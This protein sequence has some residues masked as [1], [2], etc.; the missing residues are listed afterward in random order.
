M[1]YFVTNGGLALE[2]ECVTGEVE[3]LTAIDT[4]VPPPPLPKTS[5]KSLVFFDLETTGLPSVA[6]RANITEL[7]MVAVDRQTF[8]KCNKFPFRVSNKLVHCIKPS[9][10][11]HPMAAKK[12]GLDNSM[13]V[14]QPLFRDIVPALK[15]FLASL[16]QPVCLLAHNGDRFDFPILQEELRYAGANNPI[17]VFCCDTIEAMKHVL[18][19]GAPVNKR[20]GTSFSLDTLY[21]SLCGRRKN[22]HQAEQDCLDLMRVCRHNRKAFLDYIDA[23]ATNFASFQQVLQ[24]SSF[25]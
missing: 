17:D 13:L 9:A 23:H 12:S 18:R 5:V 20:S 10:Y 3:A 16:P 21:K 7:A 4:P 15:A 6:Q 1:E 11:V 19:D 24:I 8:E 14:N 25:R 22:A 2:E